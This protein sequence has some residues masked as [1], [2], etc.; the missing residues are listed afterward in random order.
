MATSDLRSAKW[1]LVPLTTQTRRV[2]SP[3]RV[4]DMSRMLN[5][6]TLITGIPPQRK[7]GGLVK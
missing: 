4:Q 1:G 6:D 3:P 7:G 5:I 2:R